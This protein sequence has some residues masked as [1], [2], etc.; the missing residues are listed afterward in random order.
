MNDFDYTEKP[1]IDDHSQSP[2]L[3]STLGLQEAQPPKS[4]SG[5]LAKGHYLV[6]VSVI[7]TAIN[8]SALFISWSLEPRRREQVV[9]LEG[10][11]PY[12]DVPVEFVPLAFFPAGIHGV[13]NVSR[14]I[15]E[16]IPTAATDQA[17]DNVS[18]EGEFF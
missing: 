10:T 2:L 11:L 13:P 18:F 14:T 17:W 15:Y 8:L 7:L 6:V 1:D 5:W 12:R 4:G 16:G 3:E 9:G